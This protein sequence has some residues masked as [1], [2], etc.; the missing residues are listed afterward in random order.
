MKWFH[1]DVK[2]LGLIYFNVC[3][4]SFLYNFKT[5]NS[6]PGCRLKSSPGLTATPC[7]MDA[8]A[9]PNMLKIFRADLQ[10]VETFSP[11]WKHSD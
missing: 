1:R 8:I 5:D 10:Y 4:R 2:T 9:E 6:L 7:I 3:S 11:S